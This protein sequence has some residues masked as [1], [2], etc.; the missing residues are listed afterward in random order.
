M[1]AIIDTFVSGGFW[2]I[3]VTGLGLAF[4]ALG[5]AQLRRHGGQRLAAPIVTTGLTMALVAAL[6]VSVGWIELLG[7]LD[8][9]PPQDVPELTRHGLTATT[10]LMVLALVFAVPGTALG[11]LAL[12]RPTTTA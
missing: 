4:I 7:A 8:R 1:Q 2:S 6:G 10:D 9:C 5:V 12:H 11:G 3:A